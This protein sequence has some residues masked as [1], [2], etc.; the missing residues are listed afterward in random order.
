[1]GEEVNKM[2]E[3]PILQMT[4]YQTGVSTRIFLPDPNDL[5]IMFKEIGGCSFSGS[6]TLRYE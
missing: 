4:N 1:M 2:M 6:G 3:N 5:F